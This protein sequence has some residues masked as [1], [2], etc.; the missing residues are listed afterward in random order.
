MVWGY[1]I[2]VITFCDN[3]RFNFFSSYLLCHIVLYK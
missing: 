3:L 1:F 2:K